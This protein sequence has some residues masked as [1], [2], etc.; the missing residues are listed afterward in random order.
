MHGNKE[1]EVE[2][3]FPQKL[4]ELNESE[5]ISLVKESKENNLPQSII[6]EYENKLAKTVFKSNKY[7][8]K[9]HDIV[10]TLKPFSDSSMADVLALTNTN[11]VDEDDILL[12]INFNKFLKEIERE[13]IDKD[14]SIVEI[15][16]SDIEKLLQD[17]LKA[18]KTKVEPNEIAVPT[19]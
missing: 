16:I 8:A 6:H 7:K 3:S 10:M 1:Y 18:L 19:L 4:I 2:F 17:K 12:N 14:N 15:S 9:L 5:L 13:L 11:Y